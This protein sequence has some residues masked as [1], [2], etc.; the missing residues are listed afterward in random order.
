[1]KEKDRV[2]IREFLIDDYDQLLDLWKRAG[3]PNKP[4]GRDS[5]EKIK[6]ELQRGIGTFFIAEIDSRIIGSIHATHD[7]RKG[8]LNRVAVDL[9]YRR[10][11]I[12]SQLVK[13]A[14]QHLHN[15]GLEIITC[16]IEKWNHDSIQFFQELG[17]T[18]HSDIFYFSKRTHK[19]V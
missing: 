9:D 6:H 14:E 17:Y 7:G 10:K 2:T 8:W 11:G 3:L 12:A 19:D 16:L 1:M 18:K 4:K 15:I 13:H 5:K